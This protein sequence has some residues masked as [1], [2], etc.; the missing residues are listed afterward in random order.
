MSPILIFKYIM[1][2]QA[3]KKKNWNPQQTALWCLSVR[4]SCSSLSLV[5]WMVKVNTTRDLLEIRVPQQHCRAE[6]PGG[7]LRWQIRLR[8]QYEAGWS[9]GRAPLSLHHTPEGIRSLQNISCSLQ[10]TQELCS[11]ADYKQEAY[12]AVA[13]LL[14]GLVTHESW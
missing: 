5:S 7:Q 14:Q 9:A 3:K 13:D 2:Y 11:P 10:S 1:R 12:L 4:R 8:G 6:A